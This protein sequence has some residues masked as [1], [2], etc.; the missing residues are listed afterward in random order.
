MKEQ[1]TTATLPTIILDKIILDAQAKRTQEKIDH[2]KTMAILNQ[3]KK[4]SIFSK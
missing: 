2:A 4:G 3:L 1:S